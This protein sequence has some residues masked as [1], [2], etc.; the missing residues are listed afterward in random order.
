MEMI[1]LLLDDDDQL[2]S[3]PVCPVCDGPV[4]PLRDYYRC[5][6]CAHSFCET[7]EGGLANDE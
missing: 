2:E 3:P 7:C 1:D 5:S 6:R 4:I